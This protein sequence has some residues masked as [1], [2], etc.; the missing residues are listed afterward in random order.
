MK[1]SLYFQTLYGLDGDLFD[2][3]RLIRDL[4]LIDANDPTLSD[5]PPV[6]SPAPS[7]ATDTSLSF[8]DVALGGEQ[9]VE[10]L[11]KSV[12]RHHLCLADYFKDND[13]H[14]RGLVT[15][16][17]VIYPFL[18]ISSMFIHPDVAKVIHDTF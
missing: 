16:S 8:C 9:V 18:F 7:R 12:S 2:Y 15:K 13:K 6:T 17:Q 4:L 14:L 3:Q 1:E 11:A 5:A 10:K